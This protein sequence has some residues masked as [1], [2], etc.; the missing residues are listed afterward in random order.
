MRSRHVL[1]PLLLL[2]ASTSHAAPGIFPTEKVVFEKVATGFR[3]TEGPAADAK[4]D[5][6]FTDIPNERIHKLDAASGKVSVF[7][8]KSG[9]ANG[10][11]FDAHGRLV[12][13]EGGGR[14]LVRIEG[15]SVTVLASH[16][17]KKRLNSPND[18]SIDAAGGIWFTDPR[19]G[20]KDDRE[21]DVMAVYY[22]T[23]EGKLSRPI[24]DLERP[25]G[26]LLAADGM[27]LYVAA[28]QRQL[29]M[30]YDVMR[31]GVVKDG[32]VFAHLDHKA[33]GGPDGMTLDDRGNVYCAGQGHIWI[34]DA[35]GKLRHKLA[36][37]EGPANC[38]FGGPQG[39]TLYVT[40]RTSLYRVKTNVRGGTAV[41]RKSKVPAKPV[42][43][44]K[45]R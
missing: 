8:E 18:L 2:L 43:P 3:F 17:K 15:K 12:A 40:A 28:N 27:T 26:I 34:W 35:K 10:L 45:D 30:A 20:K 24:A 38:V 31:P 32:R 41:R 6:Y 5:V 33:R 16:W 1:L 13:C 7:R 36:V 11:M 21:L 23:A 14:R 25:N 4:G 29:I 44:P 37:P 42:D 39:D 22:V 19:Y 9:R